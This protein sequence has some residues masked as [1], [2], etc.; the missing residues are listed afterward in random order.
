[1][2]WSKKPFS[3]L[4]KLERECVRRTPG[5]IVQSQLSHGIASISFDDIPHSAA[6]VGGPLLEAAGVRGTYYVCGAHLDSSF[7]AR[8]QFSA[9]DIRAL[10]A[11]GH[12]IA[13]HTFG[14]PNVTF[15]SDAA[16]EADRQQN[17]TFVSGLVG[18]YQMSSFAYP[19]GFNTW[20]SMD[21]YKHKFE[22]ARGVYDGVNVGAMDFAQLLAVGLQGRDYDRGRIKDRIAKAKEQNGWIIFFT[23]DVCP[24]PSGFGCTPGQMEDTLTDLAAA[25][26]PVL[27]VKDG[28]ARVR[29]G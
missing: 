24:D 26:L 25:G 29:A 14:H 6:R 7:E 18:D 9:A 5:K 20:S 12:E 4:A 2:P 3:L 15:L 22:T 13:C 21:F 17:A 23:H 1:M 10:H 28:A 27:T 19:Y 8:D 16:L 11:A